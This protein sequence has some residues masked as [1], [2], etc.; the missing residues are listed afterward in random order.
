[1]LKC[2][3][4]VWI[5]KAIQKSNVNAPPNSFCEANSHAQSLHENKLFCIM[6]FCSQRYADENILMIDPRQLCT[7]ADFIITECQTT[8]PGNSPSRP[9]RPPVRAAA[10]DGASK[11]GCPS[12]SARLPLLLN[13]CRGSAELIGSLVEHLSRKAQ[14]AR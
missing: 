10:G 12:P 2:T 3:Y 5:Y 4:F 8:S 14:E 6:P 13:C 1:M 9:H 11:G 7:L